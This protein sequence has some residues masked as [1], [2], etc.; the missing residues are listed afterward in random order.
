MYVCVKKI[1][2][3]KRRIYACVR[4]SIVEMEGRSFIAL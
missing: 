2:V 4:E 1:Y 3:C